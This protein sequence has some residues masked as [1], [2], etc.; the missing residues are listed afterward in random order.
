[1][2]ACRVEVVASTVEDVLAAAAG[3]ADRV[4]FCTHLASGGLT[5]GRSLIEQ[6]MAVAK[7]NGLGFRVLIRPREGDFVYT[8][9][10]RQSIVA[11]AEAVLSLGADEAVCG[12]LLTNGAIDE[13]LLTE[14]DKAVGLDKVVFHR[15]FDE[16]VHHDE[17]RRQLKAA[18]VQAVLTSGG[19]PRAV[20]G[21]AAI[22]D[23]VQSGLEVV[24]GAGVQSNQ[25]ADFVRAGVEA[26]HASCRVTCGHLEGRLF[27]AAR[28]RVDETQVRALVEAVRD[29]ARP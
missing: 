3:G 29:V 6:A 23:T 18:G 20:E 14:L 26:V 10:E 21:L 13:V 25:V 11:E 2:A 19:A 8:S 12:G 17:A 24:A 27:D 28:T 5:P 1:M 4:E 16:A 9:I 7:E 15:A 22:Q